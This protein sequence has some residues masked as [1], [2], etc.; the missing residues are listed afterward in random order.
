MKLK[1]TLSQRCLLWPGQPVYFLNAYTCKKG[2]GGALVFEGHARGGEWGG[3]RGQALTL[4]A[5]P[6]LNSCLIFFLNLRLSF[7]LLAFISEG[8]SCHLNS[9]HLYNAVP[10]HG[11]VGCAAAVT[12]VPNNEFPE[13][14]HFV[15]MLLLLFPLVP[16][17][18]SFY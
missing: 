9:T 15:M 14:K 4:Q 12:C 3:G 18:A 8:R 6:K 10:Y 2:L 7:V 1:I 5:V 16:P 17:M 13:W 11:G